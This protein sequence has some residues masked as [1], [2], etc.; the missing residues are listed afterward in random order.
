MLPLLHL[1]ILRI[2]DIIGILKDLKHPNPY[3]DSFGKI[4]SHTSVIFPPVAQEV[5]TSLLK[6]SLHML[7]QCQLAMV[8]QESYV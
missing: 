7:L 5:F 1:K 8:L 6:N 3:L 2:N 4:F